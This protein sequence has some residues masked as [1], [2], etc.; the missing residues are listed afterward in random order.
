ML[1]PSHHRKPFHQR[2]G[3]IVLPLDM[4]FDASL[5]HH[6]VE[7]DG[8]FFIRYPTRRAIAVGVRTLQE[9]SALL[10][11]LPKHKG[12]HHTIKL[13]PH[14]VGRVRNKRLAVTER[15]DAAV[16]QTKGH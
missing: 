13:G 1:S 9:G 6:C 14:T 11:L 16:P 15:V 4:S 5:V 10:C 2:E 7:L 8:S 12:S 3:S